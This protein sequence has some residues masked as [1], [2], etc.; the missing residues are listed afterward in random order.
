MRDVKE[1]LRHIGVDCDIEPRS[2]AETDKEKTYV[3]LP[4]LETSPDYG[5]C[6]R[7]A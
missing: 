2:T 6:L 4:E 3:L 7:S 5:R 1:K